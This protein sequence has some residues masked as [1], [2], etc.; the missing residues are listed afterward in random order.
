MNVN[1]RGPAGFVDGQGHVT[2][3]EQDAV[4]LMRYEGNAN[5]GGRIASVGQHLMDSSAKAIIKQSLSGLEAQIEARVAPQEAAEP[6]AP[7]A[8]PMPEPTAAPAPARAPEPPPL[9]YSASSPPPPPSQT[10][11]ALGVTRELL[12]DFL[13]DEQQKFAAA[14]LGAL[15]VYLLW[16]ITVNRLTEKTAR[17]VVE[18]LRAEQ[19]S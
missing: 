8:A 18:L 6:P 1:G 12:N 11:F 19:Q 2:L 14:G 13:T 3:E 7:E 10:E 17:R 16:R 15:L 5:I 9:Q 4:T